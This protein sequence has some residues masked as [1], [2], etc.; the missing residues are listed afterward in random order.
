MADD[1]SKDNEATADEPLADGV[2]NAEATPH[3]A[4]T[5]LPVRP[6]A[7]DPALRRARGETFFGWLRNTARLWGFIAFILLIVVVFR[8]VVLPF[9]LALLVTYVLAP[10]LGWLC[11][12]RIAGR[13]LPRFVWLIGLYVV[14]LGLLGLFFT[15]FV[16]RVTQDFKR[17]ASEA[18]QLAKKV[19]ESWVPAVESWIERNF[20]E[21]VRH[22]KVRPAEVA[23]KAA[24]MPPRFRYK[25]LPDGRIEVEAS[26]LRLELRQTGDK[27]WVIQVPQ[28]QKEE[29]QSDVRRYLA[30]LLSGSE[31]KMS[32]VLT[33]GQHV[34]GGVLKMITTFILVLMISAFLLLD[35]QRILTWAGTLVPRSYRDDY[36]NVVLMIDRALGGAIRGQLLICLVNGVLTAIGL[37]LIGVKYA[38]LLSLLAAV[39]SLIPIFG[40][41]LSSIPIVIVALVSGAQ[42]VEVL[43][44]VL[45]L[46]WIIGIHLVEA[47]LLNPKIIGTAAKI[48][49]VVVIF[50]VVA[51]ERTY[52]AVGAL[53]AVPIM[54]AVQAMFVYVR[55][56]VRGELDLSGPVPRIATKGPD[57]TPPSA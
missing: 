8:Q 25:T 35:T 12:R 52:G 57:A 13:T 5:R 27:R 46:A 22:E 55:A 4:E 24:V 10:V 45:V 15:L 38:F 44:G 30:T 40:S 32:R 6:D 53:L 21:K 43:R 26:Q 2:V 31:M 11:R 49:P 56:K 9:L 23:P 7:T 50:A 42:G 48:H 34:V 33:V 3:Q 41:I 39:M 17:V 37:L 47:N 51:G 28:S 1:G 16:P 18:P 29:G 14:L 19:R 54:S 36:D 20:H